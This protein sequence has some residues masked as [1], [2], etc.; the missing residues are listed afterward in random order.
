[1]LSFFPHSA[2]NIFIA[3]YREKARKMLIGPPKLCFVWNGR[4][5]LTKIYCIVTSWSLSPS[6]RIP[7]LF[8]INS[9]FIFAFLICSDPIL[10]ISS[11]SNALGEMKIKSLC[12]SQN[13]INYSNER[14]PTDDTLNENSHKFHRFLSQLPTKQALLSYQPKVRKNES[15]KL[16]NRIYWVWKK[17]KS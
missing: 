12:G 15:E 1:M 16:F 14:Q 2:G 13:F 5:I 6:V 10:V 7:M 11:T 4:L 9:T 8:Q 17:A 3:K